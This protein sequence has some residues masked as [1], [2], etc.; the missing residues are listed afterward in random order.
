M[1][2]RILQIAGARRC[3]RRLVP[4]DHAGPAAAVLFRADNR[5]AF[6][7]GEPLKVFWV[8]LDWFATGEIYIHLGVT[9]LET[10]LAFAIGTVL[11][12]AFGLWLALAPTARRV[13]DPYIKALNSMPRVDPGA[14]LRGV[15]RPRHLVA[16]W[17]S[18]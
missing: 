11:G 2:L 12:L 18:A 7:F 16:R 5:A 13:L 15:V 1:R 17:R 4:A 9:L 10:V 14:D 6:F 8:D 3:C